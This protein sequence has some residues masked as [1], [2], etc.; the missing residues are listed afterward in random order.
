MSK[1]F[2]PE[3]STQVA[4]AAAFM[5]SETSKVLA[6]TRQG[7]VCVKNHNRGRGRDGVSQ[8]VYYALP[9]GRVELGESPEDA[10]QRELYEE[11]FNRNVV[12]DSLRLLRTFEETGDHIFYLYGCVIVDMPERG[13]KRVGDEGEEVCVIPFRELYGMQFLPSHKEKLYMVRSAVQQLV[14]ESGLA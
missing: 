6:I 1:H 9:G 5:P 8:P 7:V 11:V 3:P 4:A 10:A 12:C 14:S 2:K 13:L